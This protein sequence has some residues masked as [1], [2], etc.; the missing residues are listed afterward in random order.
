MEEVTGGW[1]EKKLNNEE[2]H[3]YC[4]APNIIRMIKSKRVTWA[5]HIAHIK[6]INAYRIFIGKPEVKI[7]LGRP[8]HK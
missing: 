7:P 5:V 4:S 1:G 3:N 2:L 6:N 8:W